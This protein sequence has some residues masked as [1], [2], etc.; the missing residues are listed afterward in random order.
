MTESEPLRI[1]IVSDVVCPWC[2]VGYRQ[3][4]TAAD[5][6]NVAIDVHWHPFELNPDMPP[7]GQN[8]REHIMQ[9][10]GTS[11]E[12]SSKTR[13]A[14]AT[15][16]GEL[17]F[18]FNF[19]DDMRMANTFRAHQ[20]LH[21]ARGLGREH[22]LK[23]ALFG[24]YFT[25]RRNIDDPQVLTEVAAG[26]GLDTAEATAVL[27]DVRFADPVREEL[28]SWTAR[29]VT[30]VPAIIFDNKHAAVGAQGVNKY[31]VVL[32]SLTNPATVPA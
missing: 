26:I 2:I 10:Y 9:K 31:A 30:G 12:D 4:A 28:N 14:I 15:M 22:D 13:D 1:D 17:G 6:V 18:T 32:Q 3:L 23:L 29:G 16:G 11:A 19:A 24:A 27:D 25:D 21:W 5:L 7:E 8:L 20:L